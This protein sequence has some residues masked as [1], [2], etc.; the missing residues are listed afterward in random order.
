MR[1][2]SLRIALLLQTGKLPSNL[3]MCK[4]MRNTQEARKSKDI[5]KHRADQHRRGHRPAPHHRGRKTCGRLTQMIRGPHQHLHKC[6]QPPHKD[7]E[8]HKGL[9]RQ[10]RRELR[11]GPDRHKRREL[12]KGQER[13]KHRQ[14][15]N[16][17]ERGKGRHWEHQGHHKGYR[18]E[19]RMTENDDDDDD[20]S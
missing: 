16:H 9:E 15:R 8:Q 14:R 17:R 11:K 6:H 7:Q 20:D 5:L 2:H 3:C 13:F 10:K 1:M 12:R 18:Q 4:I 19:V